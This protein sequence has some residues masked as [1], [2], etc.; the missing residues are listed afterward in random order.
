[1]SHLSTIRL[2]T[3]RTMCFNSAL[4]ADGFKEVYSIL[5]KRNMSPLANGF[6]YSEDSIRLFSTNGNSFIMSVP[7]SREPSMRLY[8]RHGPAILADF[9][10]ERCGRHSRIKREQTRLRAAHTCWPRAPA[11]PAIANDP[12]GHI[13]SEGGVTLKTRYFWR[14]RF[15]QS[16]E[17][18]LEIVTYPTS[19]AS[20]RQTSSSGARRTPS[21]C[22][23]GRAATCPSTTRVTRS[24]NGSSRSQARF[25][26]LLRSSSMPS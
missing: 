20:S 14:L 24:P 6:F 21:R 11:P 19:I 23:A 22:H 15:A 4:Y 8:S 5:K 16:S 26:R 9:L 17:S 7:S 25:A 12:D 18:S 3:V 10:F 13:V 2:T 1:M